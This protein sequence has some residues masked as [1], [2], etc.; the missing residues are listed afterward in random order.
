MGV[1]VWD[2]KGKED[3][4]QE[5]GKS[6]CLVKKHLPCQAETRGHR[7]VCVKTGFSLIFSQSTIAS[8]CSL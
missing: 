8:S 1:G 2:F 6:K 5:D 7:A 3:N 4:L